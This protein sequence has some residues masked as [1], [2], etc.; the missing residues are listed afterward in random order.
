MHQ[1]NIQDFSYISDVFVGN[2]PQKIRAIFDTG[3]SNAWILNKNCHL[4]TGLKKEFSYDE[5]ASKTA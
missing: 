5:K 4:D 1:M 2:P 3:S